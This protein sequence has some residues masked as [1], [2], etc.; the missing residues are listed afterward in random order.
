M[1]V[2]ELT[3]EEF[4]D[5]CILCGT[6]FNH[7]IE[8][9]GAVRA[10]DLIKKHKSIKNLPTV[11]NKIP[12]N[13]AVLNEE[14]CKRIFRKIPSTELCPIIP[15]LSL[16]NVKWKLSES[17]L[18]GTFGKVSGKWLHRDMIYALVKFNEHTS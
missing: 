3:H 5:F 8:K 1:S 15:T 9:I 17:Y 13:T 7:N 6:D 12:L 18:L 2:Q 16:D 4:V 14:E 11:Y 10:Y